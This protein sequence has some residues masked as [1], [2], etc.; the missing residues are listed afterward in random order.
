MLGLASIAFKKMFIAPE[1]Q[2]KLAGGE[3]PGTLSQS[4]GVPAGTLD[5]K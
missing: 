5:R 4:Y 1:A 3:A 2:W